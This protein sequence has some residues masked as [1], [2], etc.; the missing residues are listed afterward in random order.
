MVKWDSS[1][2]ITVEYMCIALCIEQLLLG[3]LFLENFCRSVAHCEWGRDISYGV[4]LLGWVGR[5]NSAS[6]CG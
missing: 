5:G 6:V 2:G 4:F 3:F 1:K